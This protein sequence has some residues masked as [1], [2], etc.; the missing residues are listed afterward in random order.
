MADPLTRAPPTPHLDVAAG[1]RR[2]AD[3]AEAGEI[4]RVL[5]VKIAQTAVSALGL[6]AKAPICN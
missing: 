6:S 5:V 1:L 3:Q 4:I 2:I